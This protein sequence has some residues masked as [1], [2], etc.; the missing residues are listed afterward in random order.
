M[1]IVDEVLVLA[2]QPFHRLHPLRGVPDLDLLYPHPHFDGLTDQPRWHRVG[3]VLDPDRA[4]PAYL[5]V[6]P[7]QGLQPACRQWPQLRL[8][9]GQR[10]RPCP[11]PLRHQG[12]HELPVG[13]PTGEVPTAPQ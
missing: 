1:A 11:V 13:F 9:D 12:H 3:V 4:T 7:L 10:R 6:P 5:D 8:F 2:A